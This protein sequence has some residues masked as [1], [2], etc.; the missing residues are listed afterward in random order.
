MTPSLKKCIFKRGSLKKGIE[1]GKSSSSSIL[2]IYSKCRGNLCWEH[3]IGVEAVLPALAWPV[4]PILADLARGRIT[5]LHMVKQ[6][7]ELNRFK[8]AFKE[9]KENIRCI[10]RFP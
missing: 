2:S 3:P 1:S 8:L 6:F 10:P 9:G 4:I 7:R 5:H